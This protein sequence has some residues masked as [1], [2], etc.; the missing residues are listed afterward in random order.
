MCAK[1]SEIEK[2]IAMASDSDD[3]PVKISRATHRQTKR[4]TAGTRSSDR[5]EGESEI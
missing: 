2:I 3:S 4:S 5:H 1:K